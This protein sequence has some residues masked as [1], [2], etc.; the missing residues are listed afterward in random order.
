MFFTGALEHILSDGPVEQRLYAA[1]PL[2]R[3]TEEATD[4]NS[5]RSFSEKSTSPFY[6]PTRALIS[7]LSWRV[8]TSSFAICVN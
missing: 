7:G 5:T 6:F 1:S 3:D 8:L 2:S 4:L